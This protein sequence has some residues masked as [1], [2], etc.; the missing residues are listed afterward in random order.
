MH[1][2]RQW[3]ATTYLAATGAMAESPLFILEFLLRALR[4]SVLLS[5]W[6][7]VFQRSLT[8]PLGLNTV[9]TYSLLSEAF[10]AQ[11]LARTTVAEAF[12]QGTL[13]QHCL[14]PMPLVAQ[15]MAE[16]LGFWSVG[17][18]CFSLPLL[19]CAP[20]LGVDPWP[21]SLQAGLGFSVSLALAVS[22]GFALDFVFAALTVALE[23]PVWQMNWVRRSLTLVCSGSLV[24]LAMYPGGL[25]AVL[26]Y[27]PF[28]ALASAPLSIYT[29]SSA[30]WKLLGLQVLWSVI[31]WPIAGWLWR[32]HREKLVGYGG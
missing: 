15:F 31:L 2:L 13:T 27:L 14:R 11:L 5:L 4:V 24:P 32:A 25:G 17:L 8:A 16:T 7:V 1:T 30:M 26:E 23:Q 28:A 22:V 6:R 18:V 9:L 29:G 3:S 20:W 19:G 10:S 12:W 21:V